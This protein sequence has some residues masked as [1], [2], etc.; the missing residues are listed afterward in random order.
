[1]LSNSLLLD[2]LLNNGLNVHNGKTR[3]VIGI[4]FKYGS[5]SFDS[6]VERTEKSKKLSDEKK[7]ELLE[8]ISKNED[9]YEKKSKR[10][11]R[12]DFYQNGV[13]INYKTYN[14]SGK[15]IK[16]D[17]IHYKMFFRTPGKAKKGECMF[18]REELYDKAIDFIRMGI[19]LPEHQAPIVEIGAYSSLI[20]SG[21]VGRI[22]IVP[23]NILVIKDFDS[24]FTTNIVSVETN[25]QNHCV[26]KR[27][28]N[29][30]LKNTMFDGQGLIDS[31]IFPSWG[32]GYI[33]LRHH[34]TKL[35]AFN[36]NI[37]QYFKDYFG[38]DYETAELTDMWGN[39]HKAK[40]IVLITTENACKWRKFDVSYEYWCKKVHEN[41]CL[42]GIV[43]TA[44]KSKLG[45]MQRMSYQMVNSLSLNTMDEVMYPTVQYL[46]E[47]QTNDLAFLQYLGRNKNFSN[48][49]EA[50][51]ALVKQN[52]DFLQ[53][54]YFRARKSRII[55]AYMADVRGGRIIQNGDNLVIVG[56]P[57]AMLM[58]SVG[59]NPEDDPTFDQEDGTIQC[60]TARFENDE[61]LAGFRSPH[62]SP[63]NI[64]YLH[65]H[66][67][68]N[69]TKYFN[70]GKQIIAINMRHTDLQDRANGSDQDSPPKSG[71]ASQKCA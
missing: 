18:I 40:D 19:K 27:Q 6:D 36:T 16:E 49:Y 24:Y 32:D 31:S 63:N 55:S 11:I 22:K 9:K 69:F 10:D 33:L 57:Y 41:G 26:A 52:P 15:L 43:K 62:N 46:K 37:Q 23:E 48:D 53:S 3:D 7:V 65:N 29:Y 4:T 28:D 58:A 8:K 44:H 5:R 34:M 64:L 42:F 50:L 51:I 14:K 56:S 59:L 30:Q 17:P 12:K 35:A 67:H 20:A 13:T 45:S 54:H 47:L 1:M 39:K 60:Y 61:Y 66:Y 71:S 38:S 70:L 25:E 21:I 2:F 68:E